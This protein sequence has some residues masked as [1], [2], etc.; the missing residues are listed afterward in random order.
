MAA[1]NVASGAYFDLWDGNAAVDY[2]SGSGTI[3]KAWSSNN[4]L[5]IGVNGGSGTFSGVILNNVTTF[6]CGGTSGG[7]LSLVKMSAGNQTFTGNNTYAGNT[8]VSGGTL[9]IGA[10]GAVT[11]TSQVNAYNGGILSVSGFLTVANNGVFAVGSSNGTTGG[12]GT[13]VIN[14]GAVVNAGFGSGGTVG[15]TYIG[16][17]INNSGTAGVGT[18]T[19]NGGILNVAAGG[20]ATGGDGSTLWLNPWGGSGS[21][22]NLD[23]GTLSTARPIAN[24]TGGS[25]ANFNFNGGVLQAAAGGIN[26]LTSPFAT[27]TVINGG[28]LQ[29]TANS[30]LGVST[31]SLTLNGG[32]L[33]VAGG[34]S[35]VETNRPTTLGAGGGTIDVVNTNP[36]GAVFSGNITGSGGL[37]K[38]SAGLLELDGNNTFQGATVVQAGT[39]L[40]GAANALSP[41]SG[42]TV[43]GG[44]LDARNFTQTVKSLTIGSLGTLNL[45]IGDPLISTNFGSLNGTLNRSKWF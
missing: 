23:G 26:I 3:N 44:T 39:L 15:G 6:S 20:T 35:D 22:I 28:V 40:A 10:G 25:T 34:A 27:L 7:N 5:T 30:N 2:L 45:T 38:T 19:I 13:M 42:M 29:I 1:L 9:A 8:T 33:Q 36:G 4:T 24:G 21:T 32:T 17:K 43:N 41:S 31:G 18:L 14:S 37:T 12:G 11:A 16:G